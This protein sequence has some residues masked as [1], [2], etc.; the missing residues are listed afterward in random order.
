MDNRLQKTI[1]G[2]MTP[3]LLKNVLI[4][5]HTSK[6]DIPFSHENSAAHNDLLAR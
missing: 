6:R 4:P 1:W 5:N 2:E 3:Q